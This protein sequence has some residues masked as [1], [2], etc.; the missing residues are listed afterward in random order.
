VLVLGGLLLQKVMCDGEL[1][2]SEVD[3]LRV[4]VPRA[5]GEFSLSINTTA[6]IKIVKHVCS[7]RGDIRSKAEYNSIQ[8]KWK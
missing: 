5:A 6:L 3:L 7:L 4:L 2:V 8:I 1:E